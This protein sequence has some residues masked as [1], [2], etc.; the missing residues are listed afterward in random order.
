MI[1][2]FAQGIAP[3]AVIRADSSADGIRLRF[4][5]TPVP[6]LSPAIRNILGLG[7][8][9]SGVFA[10]SLP[11]EPQRAFSSRYSLRRDLNS[12]IIASWIGSARWR[13][14]VSAPFPEAGGAT[15]KVCR[16]G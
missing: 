10:R 4:S 15:M 16:Q 12:S 14:Q 9:G 3:M 8:S 13:T 6:E 11:R 5:N 1:V 2:A 7:S